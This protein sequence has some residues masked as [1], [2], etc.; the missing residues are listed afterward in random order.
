MTLKIISKQFFSNYIFHPNAKE[1]S[2]EDQ[3]KALI[4]SIFLGIFTLGICHLVCL[5]KYRNRIFKLAEIENLSTQ[6]IQTATAPQKTKATHTPISHSSF[7][8]ISTIENLWIHLKQ[9]TQVHLEGLEFLS[10]DYVKHRFS[11]IPCPKKTAIS[12]AG[13]YIHANKVGEGIAQRMFVASQAPLLEDY[14]TFWKAIFEVGAII[15]DLTT[16][17]DQTDGDVTK[18]Y[19]DELNKKMQCGSISVKLIE[20]SDD[21]YTYQITSTET[22]SVKNVKRYHY[23]DW[24]DFDA[25]SLSTLH[26]LVQKVETLSPHI[27]DLVWV[28]CRA[29]VGRTGTLITA[30]IL[31]E[32]IE[33]GEI[34]TENLVTSLETIILELRKERGSAFIQQESQ[35]NLLCQYA[36]FLI[37]S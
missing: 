6:K 18:Y 11:N 29:G 16:L 17:K 20:G 30:L 12:I 13:Q 23:A 33:G 10:Q 19:P 3:R 32:K 7:Y 28:H 24:K 22:G 36:H 21:T 2:S 8:A 4:S 1:L 31:K 5:I 27:K 25:V 35:L 37:A 26:T 34:N 15:V 9:K 14:E